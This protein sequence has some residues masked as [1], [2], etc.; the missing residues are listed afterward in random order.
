MGSQRVG[1]DWETFILHSTWRGFP[2]DSAVKN[3]PAN[4]R[5][6][7]D[8]GSI[9]GLGRFPGEANGN[10][11]QYSCWENPMDKGAG[12]VGY[13]LW[14]V[15]HWTWLSMLH[16]KT[17]SF[18]HEAESQNGWEGKPKWTEPLRIWIPNNQNNIL[19]KWEQSIYLSTYVITDT[20]TTMS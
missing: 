16:V 1:H 4:A 10:L 15:K 19:L 3:L 14:V 18:P 17:D 2:G 12:G 6:S 8:A 13:R 7:G 5:E 11:F 20:V 9:T